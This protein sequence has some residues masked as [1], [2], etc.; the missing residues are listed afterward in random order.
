M[1]RSQSSR[2]FQNEI[3]FTKHLQLHRKLTLGLSQSFEVNQMS[4]LVSIF[5]CFTSSPEQDFSLSCGMP[6]SVSWSQGNIHH[7]LSPPYQ[8]SL[9]SQIFT[10][11]NFCF[12]VTGETLQAIT[13]FS[14]Y[15]QRPT[16]WLT[17]RPTW[18]CTWWPTWRWVRWPPW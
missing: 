1:T 11:Q 3:A 5:L 6:I 18:R 13:F 17:C 15:T 2:P 12:F 4:K 7:Q 8:L 9:F 16:W 10:N 14:V